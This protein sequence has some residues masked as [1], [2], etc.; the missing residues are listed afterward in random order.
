MKTQ[1]K[2]TLGTAFAALSLGFLAP[3]ALAQNGSYRPV[4]PGQYGQPV[5]PNNGNVNIFGYGYGPSVQ[6]N[7]DGTTV[8]DN[9]P[10]LYNY[11]GANYDN[12]R[13][14][15]N[16]RSASGALPRTS[17]SIDV[18]R[19]AGGRI[20]IRWNG[21]PR[22]V[23]RITY[24][25]LDK[26]RRPLKQYVANRPMEMRM[27]KTRYAAFAQVVVQYINGTTNSITLPIY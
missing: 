25:L 7:S 4:P 5:Q 19:E 26:G 12:S 1:R 27:T 9:D 23:T 2:F 11:Y 13:S 24:G 16:N 10:D 21:E 18:S 8:N 15:A 6:L 3:G 20:V 22:A 17:D 14:N